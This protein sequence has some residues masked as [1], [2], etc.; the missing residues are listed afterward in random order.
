MIKVEELMIGDWIHVSSPMID[1][2]VR[3]DLD[4]LSMMEL[5]LEIIKYEP[6]PLTP[7]IL[8]KNGWKELYYADDYANEEVEGISLW[9]SED[10]KNSWWWHAGV[11]LVVAINYVHELQ[12]ALKLC[13]ID[14]EINV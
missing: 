10:G 3:V 12:H 9:V 11:E 1:S 2:N 14:K 7:E 13:G 5:E 8:E 6:I 4:T